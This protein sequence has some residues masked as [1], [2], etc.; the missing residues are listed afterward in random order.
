MCYQIVDLFEV[1][2]RHINSSPLWVILCLT[3]TNIDY[4]AT[5]RVPASTVN[6]ELC[7]HPDDVTH[8]RR[9]GVCRQTEGIQS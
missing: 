4:A 2:G 3:G 5:L 1:N 9:S 8:H 7:Y 6:H